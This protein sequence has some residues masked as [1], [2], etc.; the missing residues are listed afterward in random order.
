M[1]DVNIKLYSTQLSGH[2]HRVE[3]LLK[4]LGLDYQFIDTPASI[5]LTD[6]FYQLNP[7]QQIPVLIDGDLV[8][9]DSN[10]ILVYLAK[11]YAPQ[12]HWLPEDPI[13]AAQVQKWLSIAAGEVK[14]GAAVARAIVLFKQKN[15]LTNAQ[16]IAKRVLLLMQS[17]LEHRTWLA[18]DQVTIA[19]LA[20][21][22]YIA[23]APEGGISL[24]EFPAVTAW[25][26]RVEALE[27]F[28]AMPRV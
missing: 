11:K 15:D 2:G 23:R 18:T 19:D 28:Q 7:M 1:P 3:L 27:H 14:F 20:C 17:H 13:G 22:S 26:N 21:Y 6:A 9:T 16:N 8:L 10:A 4:M 12:S 5:R 24:D 25:L